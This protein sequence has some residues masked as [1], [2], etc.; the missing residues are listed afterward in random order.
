MEDLRMNEQRLTSN[1]SYVKEK[2]RE[3]ENEKAI[4]DSDNEN[5]RFMVKCLQEKN[6]LISVKLA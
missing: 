4:K 2:I 6:Q 1:L 5:L 3:I